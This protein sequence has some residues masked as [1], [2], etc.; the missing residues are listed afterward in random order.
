MELTPI[1]SYICAECTCLYL[2]SAVKSVVSSANLLC[3]VV[4]LLLL[5]SNRGH[6]KIH[7]TK[8]TGRMV[9]SLQQCSMMGCGRSMLRNDY[10]DYKLKAR[11]DLS[12][13]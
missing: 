10:V 9:F 5:A 2:A 4:M 12:S 11:R 6:G 7:D 13:E 1:I 8:I 3:E